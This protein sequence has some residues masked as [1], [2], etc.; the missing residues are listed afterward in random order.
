MIDIAHKCKEQGVANRGVTFARCYQEGRGAIL[1]QSIYVGLCV[2][3]KVANVR[4]PEVAG[5]V[6]R[7]VAIGALGVDVSAFLDDQLENRDAAAVCRFLQKGGTLWILAS[8]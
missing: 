7:R 2:Q 3:E 1:A 6:Q 5:F 4:V 8:S